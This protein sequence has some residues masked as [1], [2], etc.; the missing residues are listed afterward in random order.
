VYVA[1]GGLFGDCGPYKGAVVSASLDGSGSFTTWTVPTEREAGIWAP[2]GPSVDPAGDLFVSTGNG[3]STDK[4]DFD[5]GNAVVRLT[6]GLSQADVWAPTDWPELSA[7]DADLG[8]VGP[9]LL[10]DGHVFV[11]GKNGTGY[12]LDQSH[13]GGVGREL[14]SA[15]AC[16]GGGAFGGAAS[17]TPAMVVVGCTSGVVGVAVKDTSLSVAWRGDSGRTGTPIISGSTVWVVGNDGH[18]HAFDL[19][20]GQAQA[21]VTLADAIAGFP[22]PSAVG[23]LLYVPAGDHLVALRSAT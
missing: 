7:T 2:S 13:L 18:A 9:V 22:T 19:A 21:D 6:A 8:S 1:Y 17:A 11:A 3:A 16:D 5:D 20:T 4:S 12:L 10:G 14:A 23:G 15:Q